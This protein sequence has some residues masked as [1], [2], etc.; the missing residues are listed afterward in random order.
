MYNMKQNCPII[1]ML[2]DVPVCSKHNYTKNNK[3]SKKNTNQNKKRIKKFKQKN[4]LHLWVWL[5]ELTNIR[6]VLLLCLFTCHHFW[7]ILKL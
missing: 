5:Q 7:I 2:L 3:M 4:S 1:I 6:T